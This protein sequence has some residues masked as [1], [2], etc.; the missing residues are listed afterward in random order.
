LLDKL[1]IRT[2]LPRRISYLDFFGHIVRQNDLMEKMM[3]ERKME[4]MANGN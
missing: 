3:I 1:H 2:R 4:K